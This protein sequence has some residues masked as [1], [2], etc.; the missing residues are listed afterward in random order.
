MLAVDAGGI[1]SLEML[2]NLPTPDSKEVSEQGF[3][4]KGLIQWS[5]HGY[6]LT[7]CWYCNF[8][9]L[10]YNCFLFSTIY[11]LSQTDFPSLVVKIIFIY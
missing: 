6:T 3:R 5:F 1:Q 8:I 10:L 4:P 2:S 9:K 7:P 11:L